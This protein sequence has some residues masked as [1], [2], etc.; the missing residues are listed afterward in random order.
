MVVLI[1]IIVF[2]NKCSPQ[3]EEEKV[4]KVKKKLSGKQHARRIALILMILGV[5]SLIADVVNGKFLFSSYGFM[6]GLSFR[7]VASYCLVMYVGYPVA[8]RISRRNEKPK[9]EQKQ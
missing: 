2:G 8:R 3:I 9:E 5:I 4:E 6:M 7:I 1:P